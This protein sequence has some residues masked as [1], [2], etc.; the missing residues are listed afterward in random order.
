MAQP[1]LLVQL[2]WLAILSSVVAC[3]SWTVTHEQVF[4]EVR[5]WC[6]KRS[7]TSRRWYTRK[8]YYLFTCEYCFSHYVAAAFVALS[9]FRLL[10]P[11]GRGALIAWLSSVWVANIYMSLF[12]RLRLDIKRE[13]VEIAEVQGES[14]AQPDRAA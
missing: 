9:G 13:R 2:A 1:G 11:G 5:T 6:T 7:E 12:G 3:V 8:F 14:A 10:L 4:E